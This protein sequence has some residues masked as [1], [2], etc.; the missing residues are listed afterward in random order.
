MR[1]AVAL[2][3]LNPFRGGLLTSSGSPERANDNR[4]AFVHPLASSGLFILIPVL[5][6]AMLIFAAAL[7]RVKLR[8]WRVWTSARN[9]GFHE[10]WPEMVGPFTKGPFG[11]GGSRQAKLG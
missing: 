10:R 9:W 5:L 1:Q 6:V 2:Y 8:M 3:K 11:R 7:A 4:W